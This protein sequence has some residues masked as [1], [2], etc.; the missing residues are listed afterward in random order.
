MVTIFGHIVFKSFGPR[1][2]KTCLREFA[3]N[4]GAEQP[5]HPRSLVSA[6]VIRF[7][8]SA[9]PK[10][11]TCGISIS[12]LVPVDEETVLSLALS[13]TPKTGFLAARPICV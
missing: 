13:E 12:K 5:A 11:A 6:F 4:T 1:R 3:N 2:E 9:I 7:F 10:L 8:E